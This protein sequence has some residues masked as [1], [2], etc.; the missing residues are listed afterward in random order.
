MAAQVVRCA[1]PSGTN[2]DYVLRLADALR[3]HGIDDPHVFE[4]EGRV[5][6]C[7]PTAG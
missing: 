1:G 4:L 3:A 6:A 2:L 7:R 5:R